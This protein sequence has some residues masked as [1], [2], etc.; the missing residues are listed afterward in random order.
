MTF[1]PTA[2]FLQSNESVAD[3][4]P[5]EPESH[6]V[7][8]VFLKKIMLAP[9][10]QTERL[11]QCP[12]CGFSVTKYDRCTQTIGDPSLSNS[13]SAPHLF[14]MD[15]EHGIDPQKNRKRRSTIIPG[16][17]PG[18]EL[19]IDLSDEERM[20]SPSSPMYPVEGSTNP[21]AAA[22]SPSHPQVRFNVGPAVHRYADS[23]SDQQRADSFSQQKGIV[24]L[25]AGGKRFEQS[26]RQDFMSI[27]ISDDG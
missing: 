16:L 18:G 5:D 26:R 22:S 7:R 2:V 11:V 6:D 1:P 27:N 8:D 20:S 21:M 15:D 14:G 25:A 4:P 19:L 17:I 9:E 13:R 23:K 24:S 10:Y 3:D 12:K